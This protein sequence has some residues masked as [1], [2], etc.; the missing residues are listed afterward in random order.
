MPASLQ[1]FRNDRD[2][3]RQLA[4]ASRYAA[5]GLTTSN[6]LRHILIDSCAIADPVL[7]VAAAF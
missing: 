2:T 3:L 5:G 4:Q 1:Q 7:F 6:M